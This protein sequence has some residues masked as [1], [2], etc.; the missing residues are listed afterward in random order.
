MTSAS[1]FQSFVFS[2]FVKSWSRLVALV[3][4]KSTR[5]LSFFFTLFGA[6][7]FAG[8]K[9]IHH[10]RGNESRD[11]KILLRIV[12]VHMEPELVGAFDQSRQQSVHT[13]L[14]LVGPLAHRIQQ[15][16]P[17]SS[18]IRTR[19][20][21]GRCGEKLPQICIVEIR[22]RVRV[23]FS[24]ARVISFELDV[25]EI[26][27]G[28]AI[29]PHMRRWFSRQGFHQFIDVFEFLERPPS[30]VTFAPVKSRREPDRES[31]RE[32]FIWMA[33]SIPI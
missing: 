26:I 15:S 31:L 12:V 17:S 23:E 11:A 28:D 27:I 30:R 18:Q 32:I 21:P 20:N 10:Q 6:L 7:E 22:I 25:Q 4:S 13:K 2:S 3:P 1:V 5:T 9:I 33:L 19:F 8:E 29:L 24:F 14:F 16:P